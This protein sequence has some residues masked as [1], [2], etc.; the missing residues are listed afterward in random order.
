MTDKHDDEPR[1]K[2][3]LGSH[4][5]LF[6]EPEPDDSAKD[7]REKGEPSGGDNFA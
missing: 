1:K 7:I 2:P 5:D 3:E 6:P 4:A